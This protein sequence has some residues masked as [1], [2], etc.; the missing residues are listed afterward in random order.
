[1]VS[2]S[3]VNKALLFLMVFMKLTESISS[4]DS[5]IKINIEVN[6]FSILVLCRINVN[7][8]FNPFA[9]PRP[10][11][12]DTHCLLLSLMSSRQFF[13]WKSFCLL[14][15]SCV[16][17]SLTSSWQRLESSHCRCRWLHL[18]S[19]EQSLVYLRL[20]MRF[21]VFLDRS[22]SLVRRRAGLKF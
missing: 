8:E 13:W 6:K 15:T 16:Q 21:A 5:L 1:M 3:F 4:F 10:Y 18:S 22:R 11:V 2:F 14:K 17:F 12:T 20:C 7:I 9:N 19:S